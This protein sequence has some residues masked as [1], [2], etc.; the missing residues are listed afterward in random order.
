M[1]RSRHLPDDDILQHDRRIRSCAGVPPYEIK[2]ILP[3]PRHTRPRSAAETVT[4]PHGDEANELRKR[5]GDGGEFGAT[6]GR[7]EKVGWY[8]RVASRHGCTCR[9][10]QKSL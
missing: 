6:T 3:L 7:P 8:D 5:G 10:P 2:D 1:I 4:E 9:A